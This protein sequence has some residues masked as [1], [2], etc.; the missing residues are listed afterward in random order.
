MSG[1]LGIAAYLDMAHDMADAAASVIM[2]HFRAGGSVDDKG[3][4][5]VF[6]PV[7]EADRAAERIMRDALSARYP[8]HGI[9]GEEYPASNPDSEYCWTLDPIDGTRAFI[10]GY[11]LWG[12][13]IGLKHNGVPIFGLMDQPF[14]RERFYATDKGAIARIAGNEQPMHTRRCQRLGE[15]ILATTSP[16]LFADGFERERF[17]SLSKQVRLRR[18]GGDCYSY[19]MLAAGHVDLVVEAGLKSFDILPLIPII[20]MAGGRVTTWEGGDASEGGRVIASGDPLLHDRALE[21]LN[22]QG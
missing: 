19:C 3:G 9:V 5:R 11:P 1:N 2:P 17:E 7:T 12:V 13:L 22:G 10:T 15:A 20:E 21:I 14:T 4:A 18:F 16:D 8:D 6:D